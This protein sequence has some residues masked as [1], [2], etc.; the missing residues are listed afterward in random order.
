MADRTTGT[1]PDGPVQESPV[2][3]DALIEP[4]DETEC[5]RLMA[6]AEIG[7]LG[8]SGRY[9]PTV[10]PV[11]YRMLEGTIV[12]RTRQDSSVDEDLRTGIEGAEFK[13][14]F[15]VDSIDAALHE[16]WSVLVQGTAHHVD[17][18]AERAE[19]SRVGV[20]PWPGGDRTLFVRVVPMRVT[21]RRVYHR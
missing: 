9:G 4:L 19:V 17:S 3:G 6:T 21:G 10:L 12:F 20:E 13:V 5:L 16:G 7:R 1:R 8:Y 15:E 11:N 18:E 14:A 2:P